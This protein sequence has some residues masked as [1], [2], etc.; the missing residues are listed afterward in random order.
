MNPTLAVFDFDGTLTR[1][2]T[3]GPFLIRARG[4][5]RVSVAA[6]RNSVAIGRA[7][8]GMGSRDTAKAL[9]LQ[10]LFRNVSVVETTNVAAQYATHI[11]SSAMRSDTLARL[12]WHR[13][14]GHELVLIT[15]SLSLYTE[16]IARQLGITS[17]YATRLA[18]DG[19]RFTGKLVGANVRGPEKARLLH[20]HL[21]GR[22]ATVYA[23]G[24]S[25]GDREL[26]AAATVATNVK[27]LRVD[28]RPLEHA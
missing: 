18:H 28:A 12:D 5:S 25:S 14:Q 16:P 27:N 4:L 7:A 1:R 22:H 24:D 6:L 10:R 17:V 21:N 3:L 2:D 23:Y 26:L 11:L 8:A 19:D 9:L 15:A 20:A 13:T